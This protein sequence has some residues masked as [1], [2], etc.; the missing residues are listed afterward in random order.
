VVNLLALVVLGVLQIPNI[1]VLLAC[2]LLIGIFA[3]LYMA[4]VPI[5]IYELSPKQLVGSFGVYTNLFIAVA[6]SLCFLL[7]VIFQQAVDL[8]PEPFWRIIWL[9]PAIPVIIQSA[10]LLS[11]FVPE[12]PTSLLVTGRREEAREVLSQ[13]HKEEYV[14]MTLIAREEELEM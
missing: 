11:G 5:Y 13:F 7:Q 4:I 10:L 14:Q 9:I 2:R 8:A 6:I 1:W 12:S 3:G